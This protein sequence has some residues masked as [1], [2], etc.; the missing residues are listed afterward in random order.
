MDAT[1]RLGWRPEESDRSPSCAL[2]PVTVFR[3]PEEPHPTPC[4][5]DE[6][7]T[8][9]SRTSAAL[10]VARNPS[11]Q[12]QPPNV[13]EHRLSFDG[14]GYICRVVWQDNPVT[15]PLVMLGGSAQDRFSWRLHE[16]RLSEVC[17]VVTVDL[18]GY[19]GADALPGKYG[20]DFL[21]A[22]VRHMLCELGMTKVNLMGGCFGATIALR[23][24]QL[25]PH[26]LERLMLCGVTT[27]FPEELKQ[28]L[29]RWLR[30]LGDD[31]LEELTQER[32]ARF[33]APLGTGTI[34]R[35]AAIS[36]F[37]YRQF[38]AQTP[39]QISMT[40]VDHYARLLDH[41]WY[42]PEPVA[43]LPTLV[44]AGEHD[45]LTTSQMSREVAA[46]LAGAA[47]LTIKDADHFVH[48]ER[49]EEF[50]DL[51]VRF[52]TDRPID[53]LPYCNPVEYPTALAGR[54]R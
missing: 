19:G 29:R 52:C 41:E 51:L 53:D 4:L 14:F 45:T 5:G 25:Y 27:H 8:E 46:R 16:S 31:R 43:A 11:G 38:M 36:R 26:T 23:F 28:C 12:R 1:R 10:A 13:V 22:A 33:T 3:D 34:R 40:V 18:P 20:I 48:M 44:F 6:T 17:S 50:A 15:A 35:R 37:L 9:V 21:A 47:F 39:R 32:V 7:R 49:I 30:M 2:P 24:A 42:R 54:Q